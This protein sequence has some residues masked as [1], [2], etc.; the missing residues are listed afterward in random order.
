MGRLFAISRLL[1]RTDLPV[2]DIGLWRPN[3]ALAVGVIRCHDK[4]DAPGDRFNLKHG[5][6]AIGH[7]MALL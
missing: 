4:V 1:E 3:E 5:A 2:D 6:T 7:L